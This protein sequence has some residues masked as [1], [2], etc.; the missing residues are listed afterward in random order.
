MQTCNVLILL[1]SIFQFS[2][3]GSRKFTFLRGHVESVP[4]RN[5]KLE[6]L[7]ARLVAHVDC[8]LLPDK[9]VS[10]TYS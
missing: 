10:Y 5:E 8:S 6:G 9:R 2:G 4:A 7:N 1:E 3:A